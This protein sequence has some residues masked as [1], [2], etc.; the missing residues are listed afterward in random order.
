MILTDWM[1]MNQKYVK[2]S[3]LRRREMSSFSF[4]G[5]EIKYRIEDVMKPVII[6]GSKTAHINVMSN[7][8]RQCFH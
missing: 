3:V 5:W 2:I 1:I 7:R 8:S 4:F 6:K